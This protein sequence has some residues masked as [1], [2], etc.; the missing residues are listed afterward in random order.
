[1]EEKLKAALAGL[2]PG[3]IH[4]FDSIDSTNLYAAELARQ[5]TPD[6]TLVVADEQTAGKG[7]EGRRWFTPPGTALAFSIVL[8]SPAGG[9]QL[10]HFA[11]L[12]A[13]AVHKAFSEGYGLHA[14]IK[15]PNDVLISGKKACGILAEAGWLGNQ[16][17]H[18]ILGIGINVK[19]D[20]VPPQFDLHFPATSV[21]AETGVPADRWRLLG[22]VLEG[23]LSWR[24]LV[25]TPD[26]VT[27]WERRLAYRGQ[28]V[29]VGD[30][31]GV[32][33]GL[34]GAG[35]LIIETEGARR[36]FSMGEVRLRPG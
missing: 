24:S 26:F 13:L 25:G 29:M 19:A 30:T 15:W 3:P 36:V 27:E 14:A 22:R 35:Q 7:R 32:L 4:Y 2:A 33:Q 6:L 34:D 20:S 28:P 5:G 1:M 23:I 12:G 10:S 8:D 11:G 18:V 31:Y 21:E 16:L 9:I 17:S